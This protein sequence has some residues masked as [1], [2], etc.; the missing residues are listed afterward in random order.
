MSTRQRHRR[1]TRLADFL[2][3]LRT[4]RLLSPQQLEELSAS[5][6]PSDRPRLRAL[7]LVEDRLLT[8]LQARLILSGRVR[9]LRLGRYLLLERL[10]SGGMGHVYKAAHLVLRQPVALKIVARLRRREAPRTK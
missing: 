2:D 1:I 5:W 3:A 8:H 9:Q 7:D 6:S 4:S 10:G